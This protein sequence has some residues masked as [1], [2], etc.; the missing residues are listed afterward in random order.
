MSADEPPTLESRFKGSIANLFS[1]MS[2]QP[3]TQPTLATVYGRGDVAGSAFTPAEDATIL[4]LTQTFPD[5]DAATGVRVSQNVR[6][7]NIRDE[8]AVRCPGSARGKGELRNR[9]EL[10]S[11]STGR[12]E[13]STPLIAPPPTYPHLLSPAM[14]NARKTLASTDGKGGSDD[15]AASAAD[16]DTSSL[17]DDRSC[18]T[19][20]SDTFQWD[21]DKEVDANDAWDS[22]EDDEWFHAALENVERR[23]TNEEPL[24][25]LRFRMTKRAVSCRPVYTSSVDVAESKSPTVFSPAS[26]RAASSGTGEGAS[27]TVSSSS[28]RRGIRSAAASA[29]VTASVTAS[30]TSTAA[31]R[32]A[33]PRGGE[34]IR[35]SRTP[36]RAVEFVAEELEA[37]ANLRV[38]LAD[39]G[40]ESPL[41]AAYIDD[42]CTMWRFALAFQF[43]AE[44]AEHLFRKQF[45]WRGRT[46]VD[47]ILRDWGMDQDNADPGCTSSG[48]DSNH[49]A[50]RTPPP[51]VPR[52]AE[53]RLGRRCFWGGIYGRSTEGGPFM[54]DRI[55]RLDLKGLHDDA[56][57]FEAV[58][59][60]V[61]A[62]GESMWRAVR[63][64]GGKTRGLIVIDSAGMSYE[65]FRHRKVFRTLVGTIS[66]FPEIAARIIV[67]NAPWFFQ[68]AWKIVAPLLP[69]R[70]RDKIQVEGKDFMK[71]VASLVEGGVAGV[72]AFLGGGLPV[73]EG[74]FKGATVTVKE[75]RRLERVG[76]ELGGLGGTKGGEKG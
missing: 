65:K 14:E 5:F 72:P 10:L 69:K 44:K 1:A 76:V 20:T 2:G 24:P 19:P 17:G 57:A 74:G 25:P 18:D 28:S 54:V 67:V 61:V 45:R 3:T 47:G 75:A 15:D 58:R 8:L 42:D 37:M 12:G 51:C 27:R 36:P 31:T 56:E 41:A 55:G 38:L 4:Q 60:S 70:T 13:P 52:S 29:S 6:F 9:S 68:A 62:Y 63:A 21:S 33:A 53:A 16:D 50:L 23:L 39:L 73:E 22:E 59:K 46:D 35:P 32:A 30:A 66:L 49:H 64:T 7:S 11:E 43:S 48:H 40:R 71:L 34:L 26:V